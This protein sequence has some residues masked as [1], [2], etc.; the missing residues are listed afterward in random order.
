MRIKITKRKVIKIQKIIISN[1]YE[2]KKL[3]GACLKS[4]L[5]E[6]IQQFT[7]KPPRRLKAVFRLILYSTLLHFFYSHVYY[8]CILYHTVA[9]E[10]VCETI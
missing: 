1:K 3:Y 9:Y 7:A 8:I 10:Y 2:S 5:P 6:G 4:V